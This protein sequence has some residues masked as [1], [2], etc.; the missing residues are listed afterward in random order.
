[1]ALG[2]EWVDFGT[3]TMALRILGAMHLERYEEARRLAE[4]IDEVCGA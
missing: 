2:E 3:E 4:A 1:M